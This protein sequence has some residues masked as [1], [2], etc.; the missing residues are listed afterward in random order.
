MSVPPEL[1]VHPLMVGGA[2]SG[3]VS[4][5]LVTLPLAEK[6]VHVTVIGIESMSPGEGHV[7]SRF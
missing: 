7:R 4:E 3:S 2:E 5:A 1:S 6:L